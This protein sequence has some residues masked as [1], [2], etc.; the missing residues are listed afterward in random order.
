M[1]ESPRPRGRRPG[2]SGS[3]GGEPVQRIGWTTPPAPNDGT[4]SEFRFRGATAYYQEIFLPLG[5]GV[6]HSSRRPSQD[7]T[8]GNVDDAVLR[9]ALFRGVVKW[10][11]RSNKG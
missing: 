7:Q 3:V 11:R 8:R 5:L 9:A 1:V 6:P 2:L 4:T 10:R